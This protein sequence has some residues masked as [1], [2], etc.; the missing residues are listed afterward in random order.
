MINWHKE[1]LT[2]SNKIRMLRFKR[3]VSMLRFAN[4]FISVMVYIPI[5]CVLV[6]IAINPR[7]TALWGKRWQFKNENLEPSDEAVK[8]TRIMS[9]IMIII[10]IIAF[11][12]TI[13]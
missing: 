4:I 6:Y 9:I 7:D 5:I 11:I 1:I 8:L 10:G 3:G 13:S 12:K 2:K